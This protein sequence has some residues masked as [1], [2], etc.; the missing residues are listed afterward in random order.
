MNGLMVIHF[1]REENFHPSRFDAHV[2]NSVNSDTQPKRHEFGLIWTHAISIFYLI[3]GQKD[4]QKSS[5]AKLHQT[6]L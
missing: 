5:L 6:D 2:D 3:L 1:E 4:L